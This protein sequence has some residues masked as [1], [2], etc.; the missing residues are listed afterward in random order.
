LLK[1]RAV[2]LVTGSLVLLLLIA[3]G[4]WLTTGPGRELLRVQTERVLSDLLEGKVEIGQVDP[5]FRMGLGLRGHDVSVYPSDG[6]PGM[7]ADTVTIELR[8]TALLAWEF[9]LASLKIERLSIRAILDEN[10]VWSF[11]PLRS[12]QEPTTEPDPDESSPILE[13]LAGLEIVSRYILEKERI[14]DEIIIHAGSIEF[15]DRSLDAHLRPEMGLQRFQL[16]QIEARLSRPW[17][18]DAGSFEL[19]GTFT[20]PLG[21]SV[22][23]EWRGDREGDDIDLTLELENLNLDVFDGYVQRWSRDADIDGS[24]TAHLELHSEQPGFQRIQISSELNQVAPTLVLEGKPVLVHL[25]LGRLSLSAEVD[26]DAARIREARL[27]GPRVSFGLKGRVERPIARSSV[28]HLEVQVEGI[29]VEDVG[30]I[31]EQLPPKSLETIRDWF[32]AVETGTV[33]RLALS[34]TTRLSE[35]QRL[36]RGELQRLPRSF[37]LSLKV[38]GVT[39]TLAGGDQV[40][41]GGVQ[42]EWSGDRLEFRRGSGTWRGDSLPIIEVILDGFSRLANM[43]EST[44]PMGARPIPGLEVL[45]DSIFSG[46]DERSQDAAPTRFRVEVDYAQHPILRWPLEDAIVV[47]TPTPNGTESQVISAIWGGQPI[48]AEVLQEFSPTDRITVGLEAL[49]PAHAPPREASAEP[50]PLA[51]GEWGRGRFSLQPLGRTEKEAPNLLSTVEGSF[52]LAGSELHLSEVE[53][54]LS[55]KAKLEADLRLGMGAADR[56]TIDFTGQIA[57][58]SLDELGQLAGMPEGF[59]TGTVDVFADVEG[60][61]VAKQH[62]FAH[63]RGTLHAS[64]EDGEIRQ[65]I[66]LAVAVA[67]AT[68]GFNPFAKREALHYDTIDTAIAL[69]DGVL[70]ATRFELE[71]PVRVYATG[72]IDFLKPPREINAVVGVF[73]LQRMREFLGKIPLM[74]LVLPGSKHGFVGSYFQVE[75]PWDDPEVSV[76]AMKTLQEELPDLISKPIEMIQWLWSSED[77]RSTEEPTEEAASTSAETQGQTVIR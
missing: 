22:P 54:A 76:M 45:W 66:P 63:L 35:W 59:L 56:V 15:E 55:S 7:H 31:L 42:A 21:R 48:V 9:E 70:T 23:V 25:P 69:R 65:S 4:Y 60:Q 77:E 36:A 26:P 50:R 43:Q 17:P 33:D 3:L 13:F 39:A 47:V 29:A 11:P 40:T 61:I 53:V 8:E 72:T 49:D 10:T 28:A 2:L 64:A 12:M 6:G 18:S 75:G 68:D 71:G 16:E 44:Q 73:L 14:A 32:G 38:S 46:S 67:T 37:L 62:P 30:P 1:R 27:S 57:D 34:G 58:T 52:S 20:G 19:S 51:A 5:I 41:E 24:V 74:N